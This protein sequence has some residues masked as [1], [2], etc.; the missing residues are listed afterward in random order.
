MV[1]GQL[2]AGA[3]LLGNIISA[4][5]LTMASISAENRKLPKT[6]TSS[7]FQLSISNLRYK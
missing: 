7:A 3:V 2:I 5:G 6:L 4:S 1:A